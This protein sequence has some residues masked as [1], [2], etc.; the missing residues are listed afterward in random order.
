MTLLQVGFPFFPSTT[1]G[2]D[3]FLLLGCGKEVVCEIREECVEETEFCV[4]VCVSPLCCVYS[5]DKAK[6]VTF[7][8]GIPAP[9]I[10][11]FALSN[12][13]I[14]FRKQT[15]EHLQRSQVGLKIRGNVLIVSPGGCFEIPWSCL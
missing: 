15:S 4:C 5:C 7:S 2:F 14:E 11:Y 13:K 3:S 8:K 12:E 10:P 1:F 6:V 9:T